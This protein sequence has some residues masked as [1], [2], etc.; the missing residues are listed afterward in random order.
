MHNYKKTWKER[1]VRR[2]TLVGKPAGELGIIKNT[3]HGKKNYTTTFIRPHSTK[4]GS[5]QEV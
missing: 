3:T 4:S 1:K 2:N 5:V